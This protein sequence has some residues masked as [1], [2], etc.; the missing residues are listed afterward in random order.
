MRVSARSG[1]QGAEQKERIPIS[2]ARGPIQHLLDAFPFYVLL[3]DSRHNIVAV[4]QQIMQD[5]KV[6]PQQLIG[7]YCPIILH[8]SNAPIPECPL[9]EASEKGEAVE[10]ELFDSGT[11]RWIWAGVFPTQL[12]TND[13]SPIYLHFARDITDHKNTEEKLSQSLEHHGALC[14]LLQ[15]FQYCQTSAEVLEALIE[16][17]VSLSWL[18]MSATAVGFLARNN[19]LE[20]V[21]EHNVPPEQLAHC[22]SLSYGEC[23]CGKVAQSGQSIICSSRS[24]EHSFKYEGTDEH[25]HAVLPISHEGQVLGILTLYLK[26]EEEL[27][28]FRVGFLNAASSAAAAALAGQ[29]VREEVKRVR[30]KSMAQVISYQEDERKRVA[31]ELHDQVC[32]SLSAL[33]LEMQAHGSMDESLREIQK[34]CEIR[35]RGLIDEVS[36]MAGQLRPT[37]LDDYGLEKALARHIEE[38]SSKTGLSIDYQYVSFPDPCKRLPA[39][40]EIGLY[41]VAIAALDNVVRHAHASRASVV[42]LCRNSKLVLLIEDD[43]R[44]FDHPA[45]RKDL[46]RCLGLIGMEE[47][48]A[49]MGGVFRIE[50]TPEKGTTVRAEVPVN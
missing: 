5:F 37:I 41:R 46:D 10:R 18:G 36:R 45:V 26:S 32:Q 1:E 9:V 22:R 33:L 20:M 34:G 29:L 17:I 4:N 24:P 48:M 19:R 35:V 27:S 15:K 11:G 28:P 8:R 38:L 47:R 49:L 50:S 44:G 40:I 23:L 21:V 25:R 31:R 39:P 42:I 13:G 12:I 14:D 3:V 43:G 16:K 7:A 2:S 30:E 6:S